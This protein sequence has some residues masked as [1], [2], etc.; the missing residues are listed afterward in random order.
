VNARTAFGP[1]D[2]GFF[3]RW[4]FLGRRGRRRYF[5]GPLGLLGYFDGGDA[6]ATS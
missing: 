5:L 2:Y 1:Q 3:L 6:V 4:D